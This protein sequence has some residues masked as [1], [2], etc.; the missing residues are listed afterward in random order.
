MLQVFAHRALGTRLAQEDSVAHTVLRCNELEAAVLVVA[1]G[2]GGSKGG[3]AASRIATETAV[4]LLTVKLL[5]GAI[6]GAR[7]FRRGFQSIC[8]S[9]S[10]R[11]ASAENAN[12]E[13]RGLCTTLTIALVMP[14]RLIV[15]NV[16]DS[17]ACVF[18]TRRER[19]LR[20]L[21]IEHSKAARLLATGAISE[22]E[23]AGHPHRSALVSYLSA[24]PA[25]VT[26]MS[27][28]CYAL[29][30]GC[31][32]FL[33]SDGA[34]TAMGGNAGLEALL[35]SGRFETIAER[36]EELAERRADDNAGFVLAEVAGPDGARETTLGDLSPALSAESYCT[37]CGN[38]APVSAKRCSSCGGE[39]RPVEGVAIQLGRRVVP[40]KDKAV[41]LGRD[42]IP[43]PAVSREHA[44]L[45]RD[46]H[47]LS[48]TPLSAQ[49]AVWRR[50]Q[51]KERLEP[52]DSLNIAGHRLDVIRGESA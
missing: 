52:G 36:M 31:R 1:D 32:I 2:V 6:R 47:G 42:A 15:A 24:D 20:V 17:P 39:L 38:S 9:I 25:T 41:V 33:G 19:A 28:Q 30:A 46:E 10:S 14:G 34:H 45:Q 22:A 3:A 21:S 26:A 43:D 23:F 49:N 12:P 11:L 7:S 29:S 51:T 35:A 13:I 18:A 5:T 16:G 40:V 4:G 50:V 37:R 8:T 44:L 48:V 27:V